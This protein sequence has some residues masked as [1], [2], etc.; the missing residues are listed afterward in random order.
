[1]LPRLV[2]RALG[3]FLSVVLG[4]LGHLHNPSVHLFTHC[5]GRVEDGGLFSR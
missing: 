1:M 4:G 3:W 5:P 2:Q